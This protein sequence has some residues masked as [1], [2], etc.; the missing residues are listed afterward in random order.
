MAANERLVAN[1]PRQHASRLKIM[2]FFSVHNSYWTSYSNK[3]ICVSFFKISI[4]IITVANIFDIFYSGWKR[5]RRRDTKYS[6][7]M[8]AWSKLMWSKFSC[9]AAMYA[10]VSQERRTLYICNTH[11]R[12]ISL[13]EFG[14]VWRILVSPKLATLQV[15]SWYVHSQVHEGQKRSRKTDE[16][17]SFYPWKA[18]LFSKYL[19]HCVYIECEGIFAVFF[20]EDNQAVITKTP[21]SR[22]RFRQHCDI[23]PH[24]GGMTSY[25]LLQTGL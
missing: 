17:V 24:L 13:T 20:Q 1:L 18:V 16:V 2:V 25:M 6:V 11:I 9:S 10:I 8:F 14:S 7:N 3:P 21:A 5:K 23:M 15:S 4:S 19:S 22:S 12:C